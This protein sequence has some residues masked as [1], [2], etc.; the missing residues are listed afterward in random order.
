MPEGI[1]EMQDFNDIFTWPESGPG[2]VQSPTGSPRRVDSPS[3]P[4][5]PSCGLGGTSDQH[6]PFPCNGSSRVSKLYIYNC[7]GKEKER[8]WLT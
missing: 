7:Y 1:E 5:S 3:Q 4:G 6:S 2:G 8:R